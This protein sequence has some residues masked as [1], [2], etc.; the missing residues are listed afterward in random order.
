MTVSE[1][2]CENFR[3]LAPLT[4]TPCDGVNVIVGDNAQGK[5][6]LLEGLWLCSGARSFRGAKEGELPAFG[7]PYAR[8][9]LAFTAAGRAQAL[10]LTVGGAKK[11]VLNGVEKPSYASLLPSVFAVVFAPNHLGL[12]KDGPAVRR[13]FLDFSLGRLKP[14][15]DDLKDRYE[16]ALDQ[17]NTLLRTPPSRFGMAE[18]L[19]G[20]W[21]DAMAKTGSALARQRAQYITRLAPFAAAFYGE[22]AGGKETLTMR[23]AGAEHSADNGGEAALRQALLDSR[24]NDRRLG[25]TTVGPH[26]HDLE[27]FI[28]DRP[29]RSFAS[30]GQQRSAALALKLAEAEV[31]ADY[32]GEA[33]AVLLDDVMSELD[34]NRQEYLLNKFSGRQVF[35]TCCDVASAARLAAGKIFTIQNGEVYEKPPQSQQ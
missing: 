13:A 26:R 9:Q 12:V 21:E 3:N 35:L 11:I 29:A 1:F 23:Y 5:T 22:L 24:E 8:L 16:R 19:L 17:R 2:H 15:Y 6:N 14:A 20:L 30:Q 28:N 27:L 33:P 32:F 31:L 34:P 7:K 4:L 18:E 10:S 25:Y